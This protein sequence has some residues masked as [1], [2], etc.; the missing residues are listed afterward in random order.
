MAGAAGRLGLGL[1]D[2][3]ER[4][5]EPDAPELLDAEPLAR[6]WTVSRTISVRTSGADWAAAGAAEVSLVEASPEARATVARAP[7]ATTVT[8]AAI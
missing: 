4:T 6:R 5:E 3:L 2:G 7:R 8:P 1:G